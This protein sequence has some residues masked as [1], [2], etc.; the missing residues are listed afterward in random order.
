VGPMPEL[1][2]A[3]AGYFNQAIQNNKDLPIST[4]L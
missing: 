1:F 4:E 2:Q 3:W